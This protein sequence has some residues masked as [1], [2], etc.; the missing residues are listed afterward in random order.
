MLLHKE[1][2]DQ[3]VRDWLERLVFRVIYMC[4]FIRGAV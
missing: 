4:I 1:G 3:G 2:L